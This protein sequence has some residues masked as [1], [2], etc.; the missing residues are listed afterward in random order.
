MD[1]LAIRDLHVQRDGRSILDVACAEFPARRR[2]VLS[3]GQERGRQVDAPERDCRADC[4]ST[5]NDRAGVAGPVFG[6]GPNRHAATQTADR[7][8][9]SR[10]GVVAALDGARP[11][12]ASSADQRGSMSPASFALESARLR[13]MTTDAQ[14]LVRR[15]AAASRDCKGAGGEAEDSSSRTS[16]SPQWIRRPDIHCNHLIRDISPRGART[17]DLRHVQC[18]GTPR[19][20]PSTG[21]G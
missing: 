10:F 1:S 17:D 8:C 13:E 19:A 7:I 11:K 9:L 4:A 2:T 20:W 3:L 15:R 12:F 14:P 18:G 6:D 21:S 16:R 5:R